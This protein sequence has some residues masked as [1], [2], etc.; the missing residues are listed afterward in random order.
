MMRADKK[1]PQRSGK[2]LLGLRMVNLEGIA[3]GQEFQAAGTKEM[4]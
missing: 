3:G 2:E 4:R 1:K